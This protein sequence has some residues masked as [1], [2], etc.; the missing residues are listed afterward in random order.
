VGINTAGIA[1]AQ[2]TNFAVA[3]KYACRILR[4][5]QQG[6]DPSPP[7]L[8]LVYFRDVDDRTEL[9]V[10]RSYAGDGVLK[11][12]PGDIIKSVVGANGR[13]ENE[14][15]LLDALRGKLDNSSLIVLRNGSEVKVSGR[16]SA[17]PRVLDRRG[18]YASGVLFAPVIIRDAGEIG[19]GGLMVHHVEPGSIGQA[20]E[21][22]SADLLEAVD[23]SPP[24]NVDQ[25]FASLAQA[26]EAGRRVTLTFRRLTAGEV[27]FTYTQ[28]SLAIGELR[29]IGPSSAA[30][31]SE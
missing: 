24:G 10:A 17:L 7:D 5:L 6:A 12:R 16:K 22:R 11:L 8:K 20:Q 4:L 29:L 3:T 21:I 19:I 26:R 18:V 14:T 28:R 23:G 15:Q 1:G 31:R 9:K 2:N 27:L 13:I 25:L 30:G